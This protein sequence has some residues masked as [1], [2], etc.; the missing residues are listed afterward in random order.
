MV[1][2]KFAPTARNYVAARLMAEVGLRVNE[3]R[4]LD[5]ADIKWQL[6]RF[7]KLHVRVGKGARGSWTSGA[8]GA[9]DQRRGP[10]PALV[11]RRRVGPLRR[12]PHPTR[13]PA[14][15]IRAQERRQQLQTDR[16]WRPA[17]RAVIS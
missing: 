2:R 7:G 6:G 1:C 16:R 11:H 9:A 14:V 8:D 17:H 15:P 3:A 5:L 12:R 4:N 10:D 13:R